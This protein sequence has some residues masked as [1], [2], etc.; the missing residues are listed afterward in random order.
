M[1]LFARTSKAAARLSEQFRE[2]TV[3][4]VYWA[5]VEGEVAARPE[6]LED[7]LR[8]DEQKRARR[9]GRCQHAPGAKQAAAALSH[10]RPATA[11]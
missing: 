8:K 5:V 4:K 6:T 11:A 7:W 10:A 3:E 1:L 9:G 2:G